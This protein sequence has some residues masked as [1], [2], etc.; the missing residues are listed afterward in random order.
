MP[1]LTLDQPDQ[2]LFKA[3]AIETKKRIRVRTETNKKDY[4]GK[5]FKG[6]SLGYKK[7]RVEGKISK[8]G[9]GFFGA[10]SGVPNLSLSS[11]MLG[12]MKT[13]F[14]RSKGT[15][16]LSGEEAKKARGNEARGRI[17]FAFSKTDRDRVLKLVVNWMTKKNK[18]KR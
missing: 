1:D 5:G 10:R 3:V 15:V 7:K 4:L 8:P 6:Y 16:T 18:L 12:S 14:T 17:F 13:L 2:T 11:K 9:G